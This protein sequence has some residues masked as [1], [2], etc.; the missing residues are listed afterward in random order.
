M[1]DFKNAAGGSACAMACSLFCC[2]VCCGGYV[3]WLTYLG[4]YAY[5]N[6]N[7]E[8]W[9]GVVNTTPTLLPT[10]AALTALGATDV[11]DVHSRFV[12]WFLWGFW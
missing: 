7:G 9:Y 2:L 6:P 12:A 3:T 4:K 11:V 10:E 8:A 1:D 5:G